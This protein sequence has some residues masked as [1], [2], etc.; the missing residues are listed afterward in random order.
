[1]ATRNSEWPAYSQPRLRV[2]TLLAFLLVAVTGVQAQDCTNGCLRCSSNG[3]CLLC[4]A[5]NFY[6]RNGYTCVQNVIKNCTVT[7]DGLTCETCQKDMYYNTTLS[8][9]LPIES[10]K[11]RTNCMYY[12]TTG[13]CK[14]CNM[15][16]FY[17]DVA[18]GS[19]MA[20]KNPIANCIIHSGEGVCT[21]CAYEYFLNAD[22][23]QCIGVGPVQN[24]QLYSYG[25]A[26][27]SCPSGYNYQR[28]RHQLDM[29]RSYSFLLNFYSVMINSTLTNQTVAEFFNGVCEPEVENCETVS[30]YNN[31]TKCSTGYFSVNGFCQINPTEPIPNCVEYFSATVCTTCEYG[32]YLSA[33]RCN[34]VTPITNCIVYDNSQDNNCL[35]CDTRYF[36]QGNQCVLRTLTVAN[37]AQYA[38]MTDTCGECA[39]SY[40]LSPDSK[41]CSKALQ[42][43]QTPLWLQQGTSY[44]A[45]CAN[46]LDQ[47][48]ILTSITSGTLTTSCQLP[49]ML[50]EGCLQ[51]QQS[52][53][54]NICDNGY[55]L[56]NFKCQKHDKEVL[57]MI[58][59]LTY[60]TSQLNLCSGCAVS[61]YLYSLLNYC[62]PVSNILP[63]CA[64]Y[65]TEAIC[66]Q[67][68]H[69][70]YLS[71]DA[72]KK[73][74]C[75]KTNITNCV[76]THI[77]MNMC[78]TCDSLTG[79]MPNKLVANNQCIPIPMGFTANCQN[80]HID[81]TK[82]IA[83]CNSC[84]T[85]NYPLLMNSVY[86]HFCYPFAE[87]KSIGDGITED[88]IKGFGSCQSFDLAAKSCIMCDP[89]SITPVISVLPNGVC[90][91][92]C[93]W[94]DEVILT[95]AFSGIFPSSFFQCS[96]VSVIH[97]NGDSS[98]N[99]MRADY[100]VSVVV[101]TADESKIKQ[102]CA[103]CLPNFIPVV[104][105]YISNYYTHYDYLPMA[106]F[107][108]RL[109]STSYFSHLI[110]RPIYA[111][112][113]SWT[114]TFMTSNSIPFDATNLKDQDLNSLGSYTANSI[115]FVLNWVNFQNCVAIFGEMQSTGF[116]AYGCAQ[117]AFQYTGAAITSSQGNNFIYNCQLMKTCDT[118]VYYSG[119]GSHDLAAQMYMFVSCHACID[120]TQ[121]VTITSVKPW[122]YPTDVT[123]TLVADLQTNG[124]YPTNTCYSPG[125]VPQNKQTFPSN[126]QIQQLIPR[127]TLQQYTPALSIAPNPACVACAPGY[128][129][130][131]SSVLL[132][133]EAYKFITLCTEI[134]NCESSATFNSCDQ[135]NP[136]YVILANVTSTGIS[137]GFPCVP[138][139]IVGC[140]VGYTNGICVQ[141]QSGYI[142][143]VY[144]FC[145][146]IIMKK[147]TQFGNLSPFT[148]AYTYL[149]INPFPQGCLSCQTGTYSLRLSFPVTYCVTSNSDATVT[150]KPNFFIP[151]CLY[152]GLNSAYVM[153]CTSCATG[154]ASTETQSTCIKKDII[155]N[156]MIYNS[157]S[158][159]NNPI[160]YQCNNGFYLSNN[161][162]L[163]GEIRNCQ[164]Y[165]D[166]FNCQSCMPGYIA[167]LAYFSKYIFC[168]EIVNSLKNCA[169]F[170]FNQA[171]SGY[172]TCNQCTNGNYLKSFGV[173]I[174]T[175]SSFPKIDNCLKYDLQDTFSTSSF[176]CLL[177]AE[178]YYFQPGQF[179]SQCKT[180]RNYPILNCKDYN[181]SLDQ[182]QKCIVGFYLST[183]FLTCIQNPNGIIGCRVYTNVT[184]CQECDG[185][186]NFYMTNG[187]CMTLTQAY[188][189]TN[190]FAYSSQSICVKCNAG[191]SFTNGNCIKLTIQNCAVYGI[192]NVCLSCSAGYTLISNACYIVDIANCLN[193]A[194]PTSCSACNGKY[195]VNSGRCFQP[196]EIDGCD[197]YV[198]Q[199]T[200]QSC[201]SNRILASDGS[202]CQEMSFI[203]IFLLGFEP[204]N[205][206]TPV[207]ICNYCKFGYYMDPTT[208]TCTAC[209]STLAG[210]CAVCDYRNPS[211][212]LIC[213]SGYFMNNQTACAKN[214]NITVEIVK[215][216]D[217]NNDFYVAWTGRAAAT[218]LG[219][220]LWLVVKN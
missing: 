119:I 184:F 106:K 78:L 118:N 42:Y 211:V 195:Y 189:V 149:T 171:I 192:G 103:A 96:Q 157:L 136:G 8:Q 46:C 202:T 52:T 29:K 217:P 56:A 193:Y 113:K 138:N 107:N 152:Y 167:T 86:F 116:Y 39:V 191:Y 190:C 66:N 131:L 95:F 112:C 58:D 166:R 19:C 65:N 208:N 40:W 26:C 28:N 55:F 139:N 140:K 122:T 15:T 161:H 75:Q 156:C 169:S 100:D 33:G 93:K 168:F 90:Q 183:D 114:T 219:W 79:T 99:C 165:I 81:I 185:T 50:I 17:V 143:N 108:N 44:Q 155:S 35:Q 115:Y 194:T 57:S 120:T 45:N 132:P 163:A 148:K 36:S 6:S 212:C 207:R 186:R 153:T 111:N 137:N 97:M 59:C 134:A 130:S 60:S 124:Y 53:L 11:L 177:C 70:Y 160:C 2:L 129:P 218:V 21:K 174:K 68:V 180:R 175:C 196:S 84:F 110:K 13:Q 141:C 94:G 98:T 216:D 14:Q 77:S 154:Y 67:C 80:F 182:C 82:A 210:A 181:I 32:Y 127:Q 213:S 159:D 146:T 48:Y 158:V 145:D 173:P 128:Q 87:F 187:Q 34:E 69:G 150:L 135:C 179:P 101:T 18:S 85:P 117:C 49:T 204:C 121:I 41:T 24:C 74:I 123:R 61:K 72:Q 22:G 83:N 54:C 164:V 64:S 43:C 12:N 215:T 25:V 88:E 89:N 4:D 201:S 63:N 109:A 20:L 73:V 199:Y 206:Y 188:I 214:K 16:T 76:Q 147:C 125:M 200:C 203:D 133:G 47:F 51:Y 30:A 91:S 37:C 71:L 3:I 220:L 151:N 198:S 142:L 170:D 172:L 126:C 209:Q 5:A 62:R 9:C 176:F 31:C 205:Q 102:F 105:S 178:P 92:A 27:T 104:Y 162:C 23:S 197:K 7:L 1:M 38:N 144:G 10:L